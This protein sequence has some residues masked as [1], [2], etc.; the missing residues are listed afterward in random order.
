MMLDLTPTDEI[1][2]PDYLAI[3]FDV[4]VDTIQPD[5]PTILKSNFNVIAKGGLSEEYLF[6]TCFTDYTVAE[7]LLGTGPTEITIAQDNVDEMASYDLYARAHQAG[8]YGEATAITQTQY[9][10]NMLAALTQA[11]TA[12]QPDQD[13]GEHVIFLAPW[14]P[15]TPSP[16]R[17]GR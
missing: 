7:Y 2:H 8:D 3:L 13:S 17:P 10:A 5:V 9:E 15:T 11:Q 14:A 4:T 1:P 12:L 6:L 16:S